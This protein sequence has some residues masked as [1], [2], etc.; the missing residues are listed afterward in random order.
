MQHLVFRIVSISMNKV[1]IHQPNFMPWLGFFEKISS[2]NIFVVL[3]HV[4]PSL[5]SDFLNR[6]T[7]NGG[8]GDYWLTLPISKSERLKPISEMNIDIALCKSF[9]IKHVEGRFGNRSKWFCEYLFEMKDHKKLVDLNLDLIHKMAL[10]MEFK[11]P[12]IVRSSEMRISATDKTQTLIEIL[13]NLDA[14]VYLTGIGG[15][16]YIDENAFKSEEIKLQICDYSKLV[17]EK[18]GLAGNSALQ[19]ILG[20]QPC[21]GNL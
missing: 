12:S 6:V 8:K 17:S 3:D 13:K 2:S 11:L 21:Y 16:N 1:S 9:L 19:F 18:Y 10:M 15:R 20:R 5:S 14:S 7:L 4:Y